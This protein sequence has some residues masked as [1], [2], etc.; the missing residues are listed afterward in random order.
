MFRFL[1]LISCF[2]VFSYKVNG[3]LIER[4][5]EQS[6][7]EQLYAVDSLAP[8][9]WKMSFSYSWGGYGPNYS[10]ELQA[11]Y[12]REQDSLGS[13][14]VID[15]QAADYQYHLPLLELSATR[16]VWLQYYG[17]YPFY[18]ARWI[19]LE[20][21]TY[22][23]FQDYYDYMAASLNWQFHRDTSFALFNT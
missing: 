2:L 6:G 18:S 23:E 8:N 22:R 12:Y 21:S 11:L 13:F 14:K 10:E 1:L 7:I 16:S 17:S 5:F 20:D 15:Y 4:T 19:D 3:Q 9:I